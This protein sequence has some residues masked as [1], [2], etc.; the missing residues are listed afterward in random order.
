MVV[1]SMENELKLP[2]EIAKD[3]SSSAQRIR[4]D[5]T[6]MKVIDRRVGL[7]LS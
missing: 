2:A 1:T 5:L 7:P 4:V 6:Q 3:Y